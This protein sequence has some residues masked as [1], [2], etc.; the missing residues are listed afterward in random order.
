MNEKYKLIVGT[1]LGVIL[2]GIIIFS[3]IKIRNH[4]SINLRNMFITV[5]VLGFVMCIIG[6][7][8]QANG[9]TNPFAVICILLGIVALL[10][11]IA[12]FTGKLNI[13]SKVSFRILYSIVIAKWGLTTIHHII[14]IYIN[15][16]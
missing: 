9:W 12:F 5:A 3:E 11:I 13:D 6:K 15:K 10:L 4:Q 8:V 2:L 14:N 7:A 16:I 1:F